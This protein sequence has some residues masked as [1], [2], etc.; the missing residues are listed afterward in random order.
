MHSVLIVQ[1]PILLIVF[2]FVKPSK[3]GNVCIQFSISKV[4]QIFFQLFIDVVKLSLTESFGVAVELKCII[5]EL[6][7]LGLFSTLIQD[8]NN[9]SLSVSSFNFCDVAEKSHHVFQFWLRVIYKIF[10]A[11]EQPWNF[12]KFSVECHDFEPAFHLIS[13]SSHPPVPIFWVLFFTVK[14]YFAYMIAIRHKMKKGHDG[15]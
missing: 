4:K 14:W 11:C 6:I 9:F 2:K 1:F 7:C 15:V 10:K 5:F 12:S 3:I 13:H 8:L